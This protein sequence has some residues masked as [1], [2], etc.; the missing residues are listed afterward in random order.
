MRPDH[1]CGEAA[2]HALALRSGGTSTTFVML[3]IVLL[4]NGML[5]NIVQPIAFGATPDLNSPPVP[6]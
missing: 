6:A 3:V 5:Q 1:G 2:R 4:A